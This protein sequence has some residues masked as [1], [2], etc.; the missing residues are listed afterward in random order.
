MQRQHIL[1]M[2]CHGLS[3]SQGWLALLESSS[4]LRHSSFH[5]WP[6]APQLARMA[7]KYCSCIF[8]PLKMMHHRT[9]CSMERQ[10]VPW[11][12]QTEAWR[13][14]QAGSN[15]KDSSHLILKFIF[16]FACKL[17]FLTY[18]CQYLFNCWSPPVVS[19]STSALVIIY[20]LH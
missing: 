4:Q 20:G 11:P 2:L 6:S 3:H 16:Y 15:S 9:S 19:R 14:W 17:N 1:V 18:T 7:K 12:G 13:L 5:L 10:P 8:Y